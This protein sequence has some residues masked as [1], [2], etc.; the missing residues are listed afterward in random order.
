[1][2]GESLTGKPAPIGG[3]L[4]PEFLTQPPLQL[5][6]P[7]RPEDYMA[8]YTEWE[9]QLDPDTT[10]AEKLYLAGLTDPEERQREL[11]SMSR[12]IKEMRA[13]SEN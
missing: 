11:D 5:T 8:E 2:T 3:V 13:K 6:K 7:G 9:M 10:E 1:M 12:V 4:R